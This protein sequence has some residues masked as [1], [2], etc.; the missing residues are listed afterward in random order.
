MLTTVCNA[1][2]TEILMLP[3][4]PLVSVDLLGTKNP[5]ADK[6]QRGTD[7]IMPTDFRHQTSAATHPETPNRLANYIIKP[8]FIFGLP[9]TCNVLFP[10]MIEMYAFDENYATQ[11]TRLY[12]NDEV[13]SRLLDVKGAAISESVLSALAVAY[14]PEADGFQIAKKINPTS[15]GK[16]FLLFP[17]EFYKGPVMDRRPLPTWMFFMKQ[18]E[19][20]AGKKVTSVDTTL[21]PP[22]VDPPPDPGSPFSQI[23]DKSPDVYHLY[24]EYE[25][26]RERFSRRQG[27][28][29]CK[30]NPFIVP[31]FP[32]V[33]LDNRASRMDIFCYIK[34]VEHTLQSRQ[35][36]TTVTFTYGRTFQEMFEI[37]AK[38]FASGAL[39]FACG[40]RE[41]VKDVRDVVQHFGAAEEF[42]QALFFGRPEKRLKAASFD[43]RQVIGYAPKVA[44]GQPDP[45]VIDGYNDATVTAYNNTQKVDVSV[46]KEMQAIQ[47]KL[48]TA[49]VAVDKAN[50]DLSNASTDFDRTTA[51]DALTK[52]LDAVTELNIQFTDLE[53]QRSKYLPF[54]ESDAK[55]P[56]P[57]VHNLTG[58]RELVPMPAFADAFS[59]F[60]AAM[61]Y[62]WR[63][64]CSLEEYLIFTDTKGGGQIPAFGHP[65]SIG[66]AY[67]ANIGKMVPL[68]KDTKM[69]P[70]ADGITPPVPNTPQVTV[71]TI[72]SGVKVLVPTVTVEGLPASFPN[73]RADWDAI[74]TAYRNNSYSKLSR[75]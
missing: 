58:D 54:L 72:N 66:A 65:E 73:T 32:G 41:P 60:D 50:A 9:P 42:Y 37:L 5:A 45:I 28:V 19:N 30:F 12:F 35:V 10:S 49:S 4:A 20:A 74:L 1:M 11:P 7:T 47:L 31:G 62:V 34:S 22:P 16:N 61:A 17:E 64:I 55:N 27:T 6:T 14:P 25:Y 39:A 52:A 15:T 2:F 38:D 33:V 13:L 63:P 40:P 69:P 75:T 51:Q 46:N 68:T 29:V 3:T 48:A 53:V 26:F 57:P 43:Y 59:S 71:G 67:Y 18:T 8:Q 44:G 21:G 36:Q 24:A 56:K 70:G 23:S